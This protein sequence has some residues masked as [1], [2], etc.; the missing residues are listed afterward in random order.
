M[1]AQH[2]EQTQTLRLQQRISPQQVALGRVLEM[3]APEFEDEVRRQLDENPALEAISPEADG[4]AP[5]EGA[6]SES[7]DDLQRADYATDEDIPFYGHEIS[8]RSADDPVYDAAALA[9]DDGETLHAV[10]MNRL[11]S[12]HTL[13][14]EQTTIAEYIV[15]NI[16]S[17]GYL[18]RRLPA[19]A[20]DMAMAEGLEPAME[21]MQEVYRMVRSMDPAGIGALDLRDCLLL[22]IE[23]KPVDATSLTAKEIVDKHFDLFSK[24]HF[25]RLQ[26]E[27]SISRSNLV[28]AL[29]FILSLNPRPAAGI[30]DS[31]GAERS[32]HI[33]PDFILDYDADS[34][35]FTLS[36][37][38]NIPELAV[39]ESF[40][41]DPPEARRNQTAARRDA[42]ATDYIRRRREAANSFIA[43]A[44]QRAASLTAMAR[45]IVSIQRNFF[46]TGDLADLKP[47]ILKD[48]AEIAGMDISS[49]SR[50]V[51]GKYVQTPHGVYA[52]KSLF[53]ERHS[54][55]SDASTPAILQA[56]DEIIAAEDKHNPLSDREL[57]DAL[58]A[59]GLDIARRTVAKYRERLGHPVARLRKEW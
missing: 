24:R 44:T 51:S 1:Q 25:E 15:G 16:D 8:N 43:L 3:T 45:A 40:R 34:D 33:T 32:R 7:A 58:A 55:D 42:A 29:N 13:T 11:K 41:S 6:F 5:A 36:L 54:A 56:L 9:A 47:M 26:A 59:R 50:A 10:L 52:L 17:N 46:I 28:D 23:R 14:P 12:D 19:I 2:L 31:A 49:V 22:Q 39:E 21:S 53:N 37:G 18:T 20:T 38:G 4:E 27:L 57:T 48:V 30:G 35:R